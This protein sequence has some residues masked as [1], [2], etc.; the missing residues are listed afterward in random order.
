MLGYPGPPSNALRGLRL[1]QPSWG[2]ELQ[3]ATPDASAVVGDLRVSNRMV[4]RAGRKGVVCSGT[5]YEPAQVQRHGRGPAFARL[6][7]VPLGSP[8]QKRKRLLISTVH[9][10]PMRAMHQSWW[11]ECVGRGLNGPVPLI[12]NCCKMP[13]LRK[14][15]TH[16]RRM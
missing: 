2:R 13:L 1:P 7:H 10:I 14:S 9:C 6:V 3:P 11:A 16:V 8:P 12:H 5:Q 4:S 15:K